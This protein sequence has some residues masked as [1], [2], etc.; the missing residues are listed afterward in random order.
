MAAALHEIEVVELFKAV[1]LRAD[2]LDE[3]FFVVVAEHQNVRQLDGRVA[4]HTL[5]RRNA[6][7]HR[8][9]GRTD[10]R[11]RARCIV[12]GVEIDH[13][14]E[15]LA[16]GAVFKGPLDID[17]AVRIDRKNIAVHVVRHRAV[18]FR[19]VGSFLL[20]AELGLRQ[21]Q[22]DRRNSTLGVPAYALPVSLVGGKL[23]AGD[24]RPFFHGIGLR[25]QD[26]S[27]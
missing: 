10:G 7:R 16:D 14:D 25:D 26:I 8:A 11:S 22:I 9:L 2:R 19:R 24:H 6:L 1:L 3:H 23:V 15:A 13:A 5:T 17:I 4:A 27:G 21:H 12:V 20:R 18:D